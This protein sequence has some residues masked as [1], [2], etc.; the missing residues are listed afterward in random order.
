MIILSVEI[1]RGCCCAVTW[2][3]LFFAALVRMDQSQSY[4]DCRLRDYNYYYIKILIILKVLLNE[5]KN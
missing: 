4:S 3:L 2:Y 1:P 5:I